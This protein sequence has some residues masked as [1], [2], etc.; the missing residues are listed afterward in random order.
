VNANARKVVLQVT[1]K[2]QTALADLDS[3]ALNETDPDT[4]NRLRVVEDHL[5]AVRTMLANCSAAGVDV[6]NPRAV[7]LHIGAQVDAATVRSTFEGY[8][9]TAHGHRLV[10][11][12]DPVY[13][14][15]LFWA[16]YPPD[17]EQTAPFRLGGWMSDDIKTAASE[18]AWIIC[19]FGS[20]DAATT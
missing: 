5:L 17:A 13:T 15:G 11:G 9:V 20:G 8:E 7:A 2:L 6:G 18:I 4:C 12:P 3:A 10:I 14:T 19:E 1:G 16:F